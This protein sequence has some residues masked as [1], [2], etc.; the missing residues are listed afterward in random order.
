VDEAGIVYMPVYIESEYELELQ[1]AD[2]YL[3]TTSVKFY[4]YIQMFREDLTE[5]HMT[6]SVVVAIEA[7]NLEEDCGY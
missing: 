6:R 5:D 4:N 3:F 1:S 2:S 7:L